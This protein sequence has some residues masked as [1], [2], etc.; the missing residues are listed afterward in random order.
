MM[1]KFHVKLYTWIWWLFDLSTCYWM[2]WKS[3]TCLR[4]LWDK[5]DWTSSSF[6]T[7]QQNIP[8]T[9]LSTKQKSDAE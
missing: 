3:G 1:K 6:V 8:Y 7:D 9:Q 4:T 5:E 2:D